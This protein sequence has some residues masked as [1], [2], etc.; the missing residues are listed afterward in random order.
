MLCGLLCLYQLFTVCSRRTCTLWRYQF[1]FVSVIIYKVARN[2]RHKKRTWRIINFLAGLSKNR[3]RR[4]RAL[5]VWK[6]N[7][8]FLSTAENN[9][10]GMVIDTAGAFVELFTLLE[11][12]KLVI[13]K[14]SEKYCYKFSSDA[15]QMLIICWFKITVSRT[16]LIKFQERRT[17]FSRRS[18]VLRACNYLSNV[19]SLA[20]RCFC[21]IS[22]HD[23][24]SVQFR[25]LLNW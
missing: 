8:N 20:K 4:N 25:A 5:N 13:E 21:S 12:E 9:R 16:V 23:S 24:K 11:H 3:D 19:Y 7:I 2:E 18:S 15:M 22:Y 14:A 17:Y 10:I 1:S 6:T